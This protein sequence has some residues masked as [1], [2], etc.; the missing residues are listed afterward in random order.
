MS[1]SVTSN[2]FGDIKCFQLISYSRKQFIFGK[3]GKSLFDK[4]ESNIIN[5][6][7]NMLIRCVKSN[8]VPN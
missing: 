4:A 3:L 2:T 1:Q 6:D 7:E 8:L 5:C